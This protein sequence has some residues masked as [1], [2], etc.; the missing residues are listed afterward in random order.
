MMLALY[1]GF[2]MD[3]VI[4]LRTH[5][6]GSHKISAGC[7]PAV[8]RIFQTL[9]MYIFITCSFIKLTFIKF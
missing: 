8:Q 6:F 9:V 2:R 1:L 5:C 3:K 7:G 4:L